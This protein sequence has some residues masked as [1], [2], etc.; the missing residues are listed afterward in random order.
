MKRTIVSALFALSLLFS[1]V[2]AAEIEGML[3]ST[4]LTGG[5]IIDG[6]ACYQ[7]GHSCT[8][9]SQCCSGL[10]CIGGVCATGPPPYE[11]PGGPGGAPKGG[12]EREGTTVRVSTPAGICLLFVARTLEVT[13]T[14]STIKTEVINIGEEYCILTNISYTDVFPPS[15]ATSMDSITFSIP[16]ME[17]GDMNATWLFPR[18]LPGET[19]ALLYTV[20]YAVFPIVLS[21]FSAPA[22]SVP[23]VMPPPVLVDVSL[24]AP[25]DVYVGDTVDIS[26]TLTDGTPVAGAT[27]EVTTPLRRKLILVADEYG[28]ASYT[29]DKEGDY[30]YS[31]TGYRLVGAYMTAASPVA[32]PEVPTP[33]PEEIM[34]I[35]P[36]EFKL[37]ESVT[38]TLVYAKDRQP[39]PGVTVMLVSPSGR[40]LELITDENGQASFI[41]DETGKYT[42]LG[43]REFAKEVIKGKTEFT[44]EEEKALLPE[45]KLELPEELYFAAIGVIIALVI[46][47]LIVGGVWLF[48][49]HIL[50]EGKKRRP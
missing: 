15:F 28:K 31:V 35:L 1:L 4:G 24:E 6:D 38:V 22:A 33:P 37:N 49:R 9:S 47:V 23:T 42:F 41:P 48:Y 3:G 27:I 50:K 44:V 8:S 10:S 30:T 26:L 18:L 12:F 11:P 40:V 14:S 13:N 46:F 45:V 36:E 20:D 32:V 5:V 16:P 25:A 39:I 2:G 43:V 21:D 29:A 17:I 19:I 7:Q 34:L